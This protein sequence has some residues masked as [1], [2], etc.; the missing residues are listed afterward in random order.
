MPCVP[1]R[2]YLQGR[3]WSGC[4]FTGQRL[5]GWHDP[6]CSAYNCRQPSVHSLRTRHIQT[7]CWQRSLHARH[8]V[9][10]GQ[11]ICGRA[12]IHHRP[13]VCQ[14]AKF[15]SV[16][17]RKGCFS[18]PFHSQD[19]FD[20]AVAAGDSE[21]VAVIAASGAFSSLYNGTA[22]VLQACSLPITSNPSQ[23]AIAPTS[24]PVNNTY[25][26]GAG[27]FAVAC[28][29]VAAALLYHVRKELQMES[30]IA[31]LHKF[32]DIFD[33]SKADDSF[34]THNSDTASEL[35]AGINISSWGQSVN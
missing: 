12:D 3:G 13:H 31:R 5:P 29:C 25:V 10:R 35:P 16:H 22:T 18:S 2:P 19:A 20:T 28:C 17:P 32:R 34:R 21:A 4:V 15:H 30:E 11:C 33:T 7:R 8:S 9:R 27:A 26:I 24:S 14:P 23:P 6:V 1:A